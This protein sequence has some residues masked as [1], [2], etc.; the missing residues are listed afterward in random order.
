[1]DEII[2]KILFYI[3]LLEKFFNFNTLKIFYVFEEI[4][5]KAIKNRETGDWIFHEN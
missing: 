3:Y 2:D 1:M 4:E 5:I